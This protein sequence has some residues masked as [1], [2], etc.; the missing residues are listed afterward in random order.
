MT[1]EEGT[2]TMCGEGDR[3]GGHGDDLRR[4]TPARRP[5]QQPAAR[6][7]GE[8]ATTTELRRRPMGANEE[9]DETQR[10]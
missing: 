4:G 3:R 8:E 7:T 5:R 6:T 2:A 1:S 9:A 10:G